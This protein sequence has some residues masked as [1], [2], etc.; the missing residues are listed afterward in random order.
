MR[1]VRSK[2]TNPEMTARSLL[3]RLGFRFRLHRK[4]LPGN[5]DIVLP[6]YSTAIFVHGCFWHR[7]K[8]CP[9]A[10]T[11]STHQDYWI[12]KFKR[13]MERDRRNQKELK[14]LGWNVIVLWECELRELNQ[15]AARLK[16]AITASKATYVQNPP[17]RKIAAEKQAPYLVIKEREVLSKDS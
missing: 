11:P 16:S 4:D 10:S 9:R 7:H 1:L 17:I 15:L 12:P 6:K 3:H 14:Q 5:P 8:G 2:N 13:T